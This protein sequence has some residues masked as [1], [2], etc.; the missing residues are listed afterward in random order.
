MKKSVTATVLIVDENGENKGRFYCSAPVLNGMFTSVKETQHYN[1]EDTDA[2]QLSRKMI[3]ETL[4]QVKKVDFRL[5]ID[6]KVVQKE[7]ER[8]AQKSFRTQLFHLHLKVVSPKF[9][10]VSPTG[11][12]KSIKMNLGMIFF[13]TLNRNINKSPKNASMNLTSLETNSVAYRYIQHRITKSKQSVRETH[14]SET[15]SIDY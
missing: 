11:S 7:T 15:N 2:S 8:F 4:L 10:V 3:V 14:L 1:I 5:S 9:A 13:T 12:D 6:D